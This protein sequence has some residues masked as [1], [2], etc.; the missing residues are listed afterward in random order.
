M[1]LFLYG[2][3]FA[4]ALTATIFFLQF[5]RNTKDR[6]FLYFGLCFG[7]LGIERLILAFMSLEK[8]H[9]V[10]FIRLLAFSLIIVAIVQKNRVQKK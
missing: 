5:W 9:T 4:S 10:F 7:L 8:E 3:I 6:L 2:I 1:I